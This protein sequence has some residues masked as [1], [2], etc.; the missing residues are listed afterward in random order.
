[1]PRLPCFSVGDRVRHRFSNGRWYHGTV[2]SANE[3]NTYNVTFDDEDE[4]LDLREEELQLERYIMVNVSEAP[5]FA[6][7]PSRLQL[8]ALPPL[9]P[10]PP[11]NIAVD[12]QPGG[13]GHC[14]GDLTFPN[15][16]LAHSSFWT[17]RPDG[18]TLYL[19]PLFLMVPGAVSTFGGAT[20]CHGTTAHGHVDHRPPG[21]EAHISFAVQSPAATFGFENKSHERHALQK[22]LH[23]LGEADI[24]E[25]FSEESGAVW[26]PVW[27]F[28]KN[29]APTGKLEYSPERMAPLPWQ[30][31]VLFDVETEDILVAY[32]MKGG[33]VETLPGNPAAKARSHFRFMY[34]DWRFHLNRHCGG[35]GRSGCLHLDQQGEQRM[36]MLG[37][38]SRRRNVYQPPERTRSG[39]KVANIK[40]DI[41][42]RQIL[43]RTRLVC[44]H[45]CVGLLV[46]DTVLPRL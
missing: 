28:R 27:H 19:M 44:R 34:R 17:S 36:E 35:S 20:S 21:C 45:S 11:H 7:P 14:G 29:Q 2:S 39:L 3:G 22:K 5:E 13:R 37:V 41:D 24:R 1:M 16:T 25:R 23:Q 12:L 31:I 46:A 38:H 18:S 33:L 6:V 9:K 42:G 43:R 15:M 40:G 26:L 10:L 30:R 8:D 4:E 32:D